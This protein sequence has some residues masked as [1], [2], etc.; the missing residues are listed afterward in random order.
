MRRALV[1]MADG[2]GIRRITVVTEEPLY[3]WQDV[4]VSTSRF[5]QNGRSY[6]IADVN[7][8]RVFAPAY[9]SIFRVMCAGISVVLATWALVVFSV[10]SAV[11]AVAV[12]ILAL[13]FPSRAARMVTAEIGAERLT[14]CVSDAATAA[15][16]VDAISVAKRLV[17]NVKREPAIVGDR[18]LARAARVSGAA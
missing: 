4:L 5:S 3:E 2:Q 6:C 16:I 17:H 7:N 8:V 15:E 14:V 13:M 1:E 12:F 9:P 18:P 11:L 10:E